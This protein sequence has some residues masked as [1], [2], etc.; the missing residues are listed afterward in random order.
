[1]EASCLEDGLRALAG[2]LLV[3]LRLFDLYRGDQVGEGRKS[4][5]YT[6]TFQAPDRSL[7]EK[8]IAKVRG[9]IVRKLKKDLDVDLRS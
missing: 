9:R 2:P 4:L 3:D 5:A 7:T 1:M 6:L 8:E